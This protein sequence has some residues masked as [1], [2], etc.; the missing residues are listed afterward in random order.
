MTHDIDRPAES[1]HDTLY[2]SDALAEMLRRLDMPFVALNP[3]SSF[4]GLHDSLVNHLGN[5]DPQ[6]LL[7][8]HEEHAV[9]IA[10]GWAKVTGTPLAVILHANVGLMHA[11][12]ALYNAWCDRVP[13]LVLGATG[14]VDAALRRPWIDWLHTSRDQA[15]IVRPYLKWDDQPASLSASLDAMMRAAR[16]TATAPMAPTYVCFDV[17]VQE[18]PIDAMPALPDPARHASPAFPTPGPA[19]VAALHDMLETA[20]RPVFLMGR[21]S[22]RQED[23]DRRVA[24]AEHHGARVVTDIKTAAAFPTRHPLHAGAP[25]YFLTADAKEAIAEADLVVSF[26]FVDPAGTLAQGG[27]GEGTRVACVSLDPLLPNAWS[28]D[29]GGNPASD[30]TLLADPDA[31]IG[32]LCRAAGVDGHGTQDLRPL[33]PLPEVAADRPIPVPALA[34]SV[35]RAVERLDPTYLR[36]TLSWD[37]DRCDW[38]GPLDYLGYDG[39]A[40]IAS[41]PG[42]AVGAAL[43]LKGSGRLPVAILGDGDFVMGG[44]AIWTAVHQR[45]PLLVVVANNRSYFNDEVHQE[46]VARDRGR[47]VENKHVGQAICDPD[48]DIAGL[49]RAQG[50]EG[51]GPIRTAGE[52]DAA[53]AQAVAAVRAGRVAVVDIR[54]ASGYSEAMSD[55]MTEG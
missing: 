17:T 12:M 48:I 49:A 44:S 28:L 30:L 6:M 11:A 51:I 16:I 20:E 46:R 7:C 50:A 42:M 36:V 54:T 39:G 41:G 38:R 40:G 1:G 35:A 5:R 19:D 3:G 45:V 22:R 18:A 47:P 15:A 9:A 33:D 52:V 13:M 4:R 53:L 8:L 14:P 24:L 21:V 23:W 55:G 29:Q 34:A 31:V 2:G 26:D 27:V 43:A 32:A 10:H 37:G 25:G